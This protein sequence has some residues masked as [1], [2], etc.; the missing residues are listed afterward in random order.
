[1]RKKT[2]EEL[3]QESK[4]KKGYKGINVDPMSRTINKKVLKFE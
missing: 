2:S 1:M 4:N 3:Y